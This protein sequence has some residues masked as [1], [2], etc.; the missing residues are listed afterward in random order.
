MNKIE[1]GLST[2]FS[3][4]EDKI[5]ILLEKASKFDFD[6]IF[7]SL[8][9]PEEDVDY[10]K[11]V[12]SFI[13]SCKKHELKPIIDVSPVTIEKLKLKSI[14]DLKELGIECIRLDFGFDYDQI[15]EM[16]RDFRIVFN[17]SNFDDTEYFELK[18]R[19]ANFSNM[20]ACHNY[21]PKTLSGLS[22][23]YVKETNKRM[24]TYGMKTIGF[25]MG[26]DDLRGPLYEGLPTV[27]DMRNKDVLYNA[28]IM[29]ND[30]ECDVVIVGDFGLTENNLIK[31][32][33]LKSGYIC[34]P[35]KIEN[36][37][38]YLCDYIHHDR[39]D[40]S[41][42]C[43]RSVESRLKS[44]KGNSPFNCVDRNIGDLCLSNDLFLRYSGELEIMKKNV[45]KDERVNVIGHVDS[46]YTKYLNF[47]ND[48][49]G[50]KIIKE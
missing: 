41:E 38:S 10:V 16:S 30:L 4:G 36:D 7:S 50:V 40:H 9:I 27:E 2:Y 26:D 31:L 42:Y 8:H 14:Y 11:S 24:H 34:V 20:F 46:A 28:L 5:N 45:K 49:I 15:V 13:S 44:K 39:K 17:A 6:Y 29:H 43:F 19:N 37:Y 32:N 35:C 33:E 25:I 48:E 47:I 18:K 23:D 12:K 3:Y 21:Y 22:K 1:L